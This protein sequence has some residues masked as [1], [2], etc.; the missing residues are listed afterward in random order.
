MKLL[1]TVVFLQFTK[2]TQL[3]YRQFKQD[4]KTGEKTLPTICLLPEITTA[5]ILETIKDHHSKILRYT[6]I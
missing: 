6:C 2:T 3:H 5:E 1:L 4:K